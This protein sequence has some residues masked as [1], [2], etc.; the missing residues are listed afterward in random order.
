MELSLEVDE[1][2]NRH[3]SWHALYVLSPLNTVLV[4]NEDV[5]DDLNET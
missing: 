1:R 3:D 4:L 5:R 2:K